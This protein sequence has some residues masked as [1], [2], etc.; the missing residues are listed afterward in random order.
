V[1]ST[2]ALSPW[3]EADLA[4][5]MLRLQSA[6]LAPEGPLEHQSR[7]DYELIT[8]KHG[9]QIQLFFGRG[10]EQPDMSGIMSRVDV[11]R[12]LH[13]LGRYTQAMIATMMWA[14][15]AERIYHIGFGGGRVPMVL[16]HYFPDLVIESSELDRE[17]VRIAQRWFGIKQDARMRVFVEEGRGY[18]ARQAPETKYDAILIDCFTGSGQH[19]YSLSTREFYELAR[20]HLVEGGVVATNLMA[21]DPLFEEKWQTLGACFRRLWRYDAEAVDLFFASD[22]DVAPAELSRRAEAIHAAAP[23]SFPFV[24][25]LENIDV[26]PSADSPTIL[27]D[28]RR[29]TVGAEDPM[30]V[31]VPRNAPCPCGS[32]KKFK[33]CHGR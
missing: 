26:V 2:F 9:Q 25:L 12:P 13:L 22:R 17:V 15:H 21:S 14:P 27:S 8:V 18:L 6:A 31:G 1:S 33:V 23:F 5:I 28:V 20:E 29:D 3:Q 4:Q 30:F 10:G 7:G 11:T 32:G 19:P 16:H 24:E